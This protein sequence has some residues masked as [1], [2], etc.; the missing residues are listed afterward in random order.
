MADTCKTSGYRTCIGAAV[1]GRSWCGRRIAPLRSLA[2]AHRVLPSTRG[3]L[4]QRVAFSLLFL[5]CVCCCLILHLRKSKC[6]TEGRV[7]L[8]GSGSS[9]RLGVELAAW[10]DRWTS[11]ATN[12]GKVIA[13]MAGGALAFVRAKEGCEDS[14]E[15]G[16]ASMGPQSGKRIC[17]CL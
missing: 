3:I 1:R 2:R 16:A 14:E 8:V 17:V 10:W 6:R 13:V 5:A 4:K 11:Q 7:F 12:V 9:G 15:A